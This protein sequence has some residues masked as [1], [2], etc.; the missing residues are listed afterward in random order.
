[1]TLND[2]EIASRQNSPKKKMKFDGFANPNVFAIAK[3]P[4]GKIAQSI[5]ATTKKSQSNEYFN[6]SFS[7]ATSRNTKRSS[8]AQKSTTTNRNAIDMCFILFYY[9]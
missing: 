2:R 8:I 4:L 7:W 9:S 1:M 5:T 3:I 6:I